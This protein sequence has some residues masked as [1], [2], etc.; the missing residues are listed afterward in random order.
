MIFCM[1]VLTNEHSSAIMSEMGPL[2]LTVHKVMLHKNIEYC[3][4]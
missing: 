3:W 2:E 4:I 1:S